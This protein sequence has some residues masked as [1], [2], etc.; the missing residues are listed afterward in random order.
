VGEEARIES[1]SIVSSQLQKKK[2]KK[3]KGTRCGDLDQGIALEY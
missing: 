2:K 1:G 3:K